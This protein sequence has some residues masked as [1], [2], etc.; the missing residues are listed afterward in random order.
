MLDIPRAY[1]LN[2]LFP[3][4]DRVIG[5]ALR[6]FGEFA[7]AE[8]D[9]ISAYLDGDSPGHVIDV[10]ANIGTICLP[11]ARERPTWRFTAIEAH[12]ALA[13]VLSANVFGNHLYNVDVLN[14][15]AGAA[16]GIVGFPAVRLDSHSNFGVLRPGL[17]TGDPV[18]RARVCT[19][20]EVAAADTRFI[21]VD[22]EG[23]EPDVLAGASQ[24]L[25]DVRPTW[26]LEANDNTVE[27]NRRCLSLLRTAGYD[28]YWFYSP[29]LSRSGHNKRTSYEPKQSGDGNILAVPSGGPNLWDLPTV[30]DEVLM[31]KDAGLFPYLKRYG[32]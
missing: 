4:S 14:A 12:R 3:E 26:L 2:F 30:G 11:I 32:F 24:T 15:V 17:E 6:T 23:G 27:A 20:D 9:L 10:G 8:V 1:G 5:A 7:R 29:V 31:P 28:A 19:I 22:V 13:Q 21:K 18:E 16:E 25:A